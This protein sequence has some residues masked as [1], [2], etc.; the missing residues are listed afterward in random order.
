MKNIIAI[1]FFTVCT[2]VLADQKVIS[3][4][5]KSEFEHDAELI[6]IHFS[7]ANQTKKNTT[8]AKNEVDNI[9]SKII[10]SLLTLGVK[11]KDIVSS[12]F[13]VDSNRPYRNNCPQA[14]V[15]VVERNIE[16]RLKDLTL[17]RSA[18]DTIVNNGATSIRDIQSELM[19]RKKYEQKAMKEAIRDAKEQAKFLVEG[20]EATLGGVHR[21]GERTIQHN[22]RIQEAFARSRI[23][24]T[25]GLV[26]PYEFRPM[27]V[28]I[29][30]QVHVE[31][32]INE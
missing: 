5:G 31:F 12:A 30:A 21:I 1:L 20:F 18:V 4:I 10:R 22:P 16:L 8:E 25:P 26:E 32:E 13:R 2:H 27:P 3:V 28:V 15:S 24:E 19:N 23:K 9:T 29:H 6:N 11:E 14:L 7:V 17:Y